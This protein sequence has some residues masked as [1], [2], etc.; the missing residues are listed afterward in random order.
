MF[1]SL[2]RF[3]PNFSTKSSISESSTLAA[4]MQLNY[5]SFDNMTLR[6][7]IK[8]YT[9]C[10]PVYDAT[11]RIAESCLDIPIALKEKDKQVFIYK[12]PFLDLL[13]KPNPY[14]DQEEFLE[15]IYNTYLLFNNLFIHISGIGKPLE[16]Y[17]LKPQN[18]E[19]RCDSNG[20]PTELVHTTGNSG[21]PVRYIYNPVKKGFFDDK[22]SEAIHLRGYNPDTKT[23]TSGY[24]GIPRIQPLQVEILQYILLNTHNHALLKNQGRPS[25]LITYKGSPMDLSDEMVTRMES[26]FKEM[27]SGAE[28]AGRM[29]FLTGD[30]DFKQ[31]SE[32][33]KDMDFPK[34]ATRLSE[35]IYKA[36]HIP[37]PFVTNDKTTMSNLG[38]SQVMYYRDAVFPIISRVTKFLMRRILHTRYGDSEKYVLAFDE[39]TVSVIRDQL[40]K[41]TDRISKACVLTTNELRSRIGYESIS[42]GDA[43]QV[44]LNM[45]ALGQDQ[46]TDDQR[47][48]PA[49]KQSEE[50]VKLVLKRYN[51]S[52]AEIELYLNNA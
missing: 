2:N 50:Y 24:F 35:N 48:K 40:I 3:I 51:Y 36:Y 20:Y 27:L 18:M 49:K 41:D 21:V 15:E 32:S 38:E 16:L 26:S 34:L 25:G 47:T 10:S 42:D 7:I 17:V 44:P 45:Q 37:L 46:F 8:N 28:N 1:K 29:P 13:A 9:A 11:N 19:Y 23:N 22:G 30:F 14:Q 43:V 39:T 33:I 52:D 6:Q 4:I 5:E 31:L 12:H